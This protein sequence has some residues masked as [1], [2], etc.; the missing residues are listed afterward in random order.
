MHAEN[1]ARFVTLGLGY[2]GGLLLVVW[3]ERAVD[4]IRIISARRASPS[5]ARHYRGN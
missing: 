5:E 1:E 3:T 4:S 2:A